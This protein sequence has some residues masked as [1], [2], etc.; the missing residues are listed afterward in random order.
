MLKSREHNCPQCNTEKK[1]DGIKLFV[2]EG[3]GK[4]FFFCGNCLNEFELQNDVMVLTKKMDIEESVENSKE[5]VETIFVEA[6]GYTCG[7]TA[8]I[9]DVIENQTNSEEN[10]DSE[11]DK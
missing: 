3:E 8:H 4:N 1:K 6:T 5:Q 2:V 7:K 10:P 9:E 11:M